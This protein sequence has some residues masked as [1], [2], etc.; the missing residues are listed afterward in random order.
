[1][2]LNGQRPIHLFTGEALRLNF[3]NPRL[4]PH[5]P[6]CFASPSEHITPF[7]RKCRT[8]AMFANTELQPCSFVCPCETY[9]TYIWYGGT[10]PLWAP[11]VPLG[12]HRNKWRPLQHSP[13]FYFKIQ[14]I[15][16][17]NIVK[18]S[19]TSNKFLSFLF[20][21]LKPCF[22]QQ[23]WCTSRVSCGPSSFLHVH[24][25]PWSHNSR[26]SISFYF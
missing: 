13:L 5:C 1:M 10:V 16:P 17:T 18:H 19:F 7:P 9:W 21:W 6:S 20:E 22:H 14:S 23:N 8:F 15:K 11:P 25:S 12:F 4:T 26:H 3:F 2:K 24:A